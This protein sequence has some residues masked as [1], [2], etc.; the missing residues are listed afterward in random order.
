MVMI[1]NGGNQV[2]ESRKRV[3]EKEEIESL[4]F[5]TYQKSVTFLKSHRLK[6]L[7]PNKF[8][9][10]TT[11]N[12]LIYKVRQMIHK[13]EIFREIRITLIA[14]LKNCMKT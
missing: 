10:W 8:Y 9:C 6:I 5:S 14:A 1:S 4:K 13:L 2:F 7:P 11:K 3:F 12:M